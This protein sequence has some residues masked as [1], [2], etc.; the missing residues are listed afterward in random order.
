M[1]WKIFRALG[2]ETRL[3]IFEYVRS[4][5]YDCR[6][7]AKDECRVPTQDRT[8]CVSH[9]SRKF[10]HVGQSAISQHLKILHEA[11][12]LARHKI[13]SWVY[14]TISTSAV[15]Q[16]QAFLA[17]DVD[18]FGFGSAS[19]RARTKQT[20][21]SLALLNRTKVPSRKEP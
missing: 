9:V 14:Y 3:E 18:A 6:S 16:L 20:A 15:E 13:G 1:L 19:N 17:S 11:G 5:E 2:N 8:V 10:G 4:Q 7:N 21:P 12:L